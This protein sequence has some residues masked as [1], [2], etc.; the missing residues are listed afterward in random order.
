[1][2]GMAK[3]RESTGIKKRDLLYPT[4]GDICALIRRDRGNNGVVTLEHRTPFFNL[5]GPR[6]RKI[7]PGIRVMLKY[8]IGV[9]SSCS[10]NGMV[11]LK[12]G[13]SFSFVFIQQP[14]TRRVRP[15]P[16]RPRR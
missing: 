8:A 12:M 13:N 2:A 14:E 10:V 7:S 16:V 3:K 11:G 1:M 6:L 9:P 15:G 5:S 4:N